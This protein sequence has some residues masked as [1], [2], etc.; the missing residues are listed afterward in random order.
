MYMAW[1]SRQDLLYLPYTSLDG[2]YLFLSRFFH[3]Y[4]LDADTP[5][6]GGMPSYSTRGGN[7]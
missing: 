2:L 7:T 6:G 4:F 1:I 5:L 3:L